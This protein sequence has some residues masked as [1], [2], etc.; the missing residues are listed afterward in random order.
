MV[1]TFSKASFLPNSC[2]L[3][4]L[5]IQSSLIFPDWAVQCFLCSHL[6][7][8]RSLHLQKIKCTRHCWADVYTFNIE[9]GI[10]LTWMNSCFLCNTCSL[11]GLKSTQNQQSGWGHPIFEW[12]G[13]KLY[14][15]KLCCVS[16]PQVSMQL[17]RLCC[18]LCLSFPCL[19]QLFS[20]PGSNLLV[21]A[22]QQVSYSEF[23]PHPQL[24][25]QKIRAA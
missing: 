19:N 1:N 2:F 11:Q 7:I 18:Y 17:Q 25:P 12:E 5:L 8:T 13:T 3:F 15:N 10:F 20:P 22:Q 4:R 21:A 9:L 23:S 24:S 14:R 16:R 6:I